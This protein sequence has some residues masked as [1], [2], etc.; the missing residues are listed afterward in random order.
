MGGGLNPA[1]GHL[2]PFT[3][4]LTHLVVDRPGR[5]QTGEMASLEVRHAGDT[6]PTSF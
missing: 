3:R 5:H 1:C 6:P 2:G 4:T